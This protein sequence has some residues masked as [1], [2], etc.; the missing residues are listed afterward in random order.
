MMLMYELLIYGPAVPPDM[1][2]FFTRLM[3]SSSKANSWQNS[4]RDF[5]KIYIHVETTLVEILTTQSM[6]M[7]TK[8]IKNILSCAICIGCVVYKTRPQQ[9]KIKYIL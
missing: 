9:L 8:T 2:H 4:L 5:K 6:L 7:K 1:V 3:I